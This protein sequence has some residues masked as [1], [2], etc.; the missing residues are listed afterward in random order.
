MREFV[1]LLRREISF[2]LVAINEW[3]TKYPNAS[4]RKSEFLG[5]RS[6]SWSV[7]TGSHQRADV[8]NFIAIGWNSEPDASKLTDSCWRA[9][10]SWR[11]PWDI[12]RHVLMIEQYICRGGN[13]AWSTLD[14]F[15][16]RLHEKA[17]TAD[18]FIL[19]ADESA[20]RGRNVPS[21]KKIC[22]IDE[23]LLLYSFELGIP[24]E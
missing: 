19:V 23:T 21:Q 13:A 16:R 2:V 14:H 24:T 6:E 7:S 9:V 11:R 18:G 10:S 12:Q 3:E 17:M 22:S 1:V 15:L 8:D 4:R 5:S 20:A